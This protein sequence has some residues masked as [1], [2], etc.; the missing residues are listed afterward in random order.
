[1]N[2]CAS[3]NARFPGL[4]IVFIEGGGDNPAPMVGAS[5]EVMERAAKKTRGEPHF[6]S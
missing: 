3:A 6:A 2:E 5:R 1:M 4:E